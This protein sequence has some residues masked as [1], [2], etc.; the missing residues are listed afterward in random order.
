MARADK[1]GGG[2]RRQFADEEKGGKRKKV[3]EMPEVGISEEAI[4]VAFYCQGQKSERRYGKPFK[5]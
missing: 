3:L 5:A 1:E 4:N 2:N